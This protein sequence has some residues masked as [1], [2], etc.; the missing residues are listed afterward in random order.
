MCYIALF[1]T[2]LCSGIALQ[3]GTNPKDWLTQS[4]VIARI[5]SVSRQPKEPYHV[6]VELLATLTGPLDAAQN[7][8]LSAI[9]YFGFGASATL[10]VPIKG[11]IAI[12]ILRRVEDGPL[13]SIPNDRMT[14]MPKDA[15]VI[16]ISGLDDPKVVVVLNKLTEIRQKHP[17]LDAR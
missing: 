3:D 9:G 14:F 11:D 7:R 16:P 5:E 1:A 8:H 10:E 6:D 13:F 12:I 2:S 4:V 17:K 15:A